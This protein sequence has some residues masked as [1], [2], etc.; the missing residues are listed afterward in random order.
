[1]AILTIIHAPDP[2]L[3]VTCEPVTAVDEE[4]RRLMDDMVETMY[5]APGIGLAAPQVGASDRLIVLDIPPDEE[6][7]RVGT[8]LLKLV[9]PVIAEHDGMIVWEEGCL[10]VPDFTAP[11]DRARRILLRAWTLDEK[12]TEIEAE[13]LFA[14]AIQHELDHLNGTL[15]LDHLSLLK[16]QLYRKR[17]R[18]LDKQGR[19]GQESRPRPY[20]I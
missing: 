8:G 2:R 17:Q 16:R 11:V 15:F 4:I 20:L 7:G 18:K 12:E 13:D 10:S 6:S 3:K 19:A 9:N 5:A 14:V 1:M